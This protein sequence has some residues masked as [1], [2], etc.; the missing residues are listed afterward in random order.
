MF[1]YRYV[2][3]KNSGPKIIINDK[4]ILIN[5]GLWLGLL[6]KNDLIGLTG[7]RY[8]NIIELI[9]IIYKVV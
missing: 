6:T 3:T 9:K 2:E 4:S 8:I 5:M 7:D 1:G